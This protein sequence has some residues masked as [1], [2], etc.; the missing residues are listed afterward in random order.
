MC[1]KL[2]LDF[3]ARADRLRHTWGTPHQLLARFE[4]P[5]DARSNDLVG[6]ELTLAQGPVRLSFGF[7]CYGWDLEDFANRLEALHETLDGDATF[8]NQE[9]SVEI[10]LHVADR[11]L[12][13]ISVSV[14]LEPH[15]VCAVTEDRD[16]RTL[17]FDGFAI[18][19]SYLP[20][21]AAQIR[22]FLTDNCICTRH[23][24]M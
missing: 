12:G 24:M 10:A 23:P 19:Q 20:G 11:G 3:D 1:S 18:D 21:L 7:V 5:Y 14:R 2:E 13:L 9:G 22:R 8:I 6:G 15:V 4:L 17:E 16:S